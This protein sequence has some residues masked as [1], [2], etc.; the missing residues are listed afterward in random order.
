V[1]PAELFNPLDPVQAVALLYVF[2]VAF[3]LGRR[4]ETTC[5]G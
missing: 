3:W 1:S 4:E 2:A 5:T